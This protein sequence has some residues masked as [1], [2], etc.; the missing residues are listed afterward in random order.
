MEG[1]SLAWLVGLKAVCCGVP[2]VFVAVASGALALV[3]VA[4][5]LTVLLALGGLLLV[6]RRRARFA[7]QVPQTAR[8]SRVTTGSR[9]R[10]GS[11]V[12][13]EGDLVR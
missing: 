2:L 7:Q 4:V 3:D 6:G 13:R 8:A 12:D 11:Q 1:K 9:T 10:A 5:G